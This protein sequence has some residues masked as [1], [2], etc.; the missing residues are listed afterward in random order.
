MAER[1]NS[2]VSPIP[3]QPDLRAFVS[4][5]S[6]PPHCVA[7]QVTNN[8]C[9]P[10]LRPG[11]I[12]IVDTR[13]REPAP[14][15]LFVIEYG[16]GRRPT[17]QIVELYTKRTGWWANACNR[18]RSYN[19]DLRAVSGADGPYAMEGEGLDYLCDKL[20]GQV[21]GILEPAFEEPKR[22]AA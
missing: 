17:R 15:E 12:A 16:R 21:V 2:T 6:L 8:D 10:H 3:Q 18:P 22:L 14:H 7:F 1:E 4:Y 13:Q 19:P 11:D 20:V 5:T 9:L